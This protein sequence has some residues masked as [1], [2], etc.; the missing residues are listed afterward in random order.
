[1]KNST[2]TIIG[3]SEPGNSDKVLEGIAKESWKFSIV[4]RHWSKPL[5][6]S[7]KCALALIIYIF[8]FYYSFFVTNGNLM[9]NR[10]D[11]SPTILYLRS[12]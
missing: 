1:M 9:K 3:N 5:R 2:S 11:F 12:D 7:I 6:V 10:Y 8:L 4:E